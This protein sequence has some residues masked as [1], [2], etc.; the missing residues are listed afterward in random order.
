MPTVIACGTHLPDR[1][2]E[3]GNQT[4]YLLYSS[5]GVFAHAA[6]RHCAVDVQTQLATSWQS[7]RRCSRRRLAERRSWPLFTLP[8]PFSGDA[9][10]AYRGADVGENTIPASYR[11]SRERPSRNPTWPGGH[12]A[13]RRRGSSRGCGAARRP[14]WRSEAEAMGRQQQTVPEESRRPAAAPSVLGI[15]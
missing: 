9:F 10:S 8:P 12:R 5:F 13:A 15:H 4:R 11:P 14:R 3:N 2:R 7:L 6:R 1:L